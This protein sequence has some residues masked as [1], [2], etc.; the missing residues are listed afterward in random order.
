MENKAG[1]HGSDLEKIEEV[2][3]IPVEEIVAFGSNVNPLGVSPVMKEGLAKAIDVVTG[4]PDREYTALR[5]AI[6]DYT[7]VDVSRIMVGNGSTELISLAMQ[8]THPKMAC[9][10]GPTYSEY[11]REIP[12]GG[13]DCFF[14]LLQAKDDFSLDQEQLFQ[15][16]EDRSA[17][18]LVICNP[19]NPTSTA[20]TVQELAPILSFCRQRKILVVI[21]ETYVEFSPND[22]SYNTITETTSD[23]GKDGSDVM[24]EKTHNHSISSCS[25]YSAV[26]LLDDFDNLLILR[27]TSKFFAV[28]G[29]RLGYAL[30]GNEKLLSQMKELQN[31]WSVNSLAA[32]GGELMFTDYAYINQTKSL[33]ASERERIFTRLLSIPGLKPY[34]PT[35][36]FI[37]VEILDDE[38]NAFGLFE[39]AIKEKMMI[40]DCSDFPGLGPRF[41]RF[42]FLN[43]DENERLL[44]CIENYITVK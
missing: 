33:I 37:L 7:G 36:N 40:R 16:M 15:Q 21:D 32:K 23:S 29:L 31:P 26:S 9:I 2:Y 14:Y 41:F 39:Y 17:D 12:L 35:A 22:S 27:G 8:I 4:Y 25:V 28:P 10:V 43:P 34:R 1:F 18:L 42:C 38:K 13:G 44:T 5:R 24:N 30:C 19:N 3:G 11:R 6:G 20:L